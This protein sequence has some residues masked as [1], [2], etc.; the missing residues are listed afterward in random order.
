MFRRFLLAALVVVSLASLTQETQAAQ[1]CCRKSAICG[2]FEGYGRGPFGHGYFA[3]GG[4]C[5][6]P[7]STC[8]GCRIQ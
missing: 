2:F 4:Y 6:Q 1:R 8:C 7:N 3:Y 5:P